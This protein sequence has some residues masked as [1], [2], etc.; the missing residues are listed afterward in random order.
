M[1]KRNVIEEDITPEFNKQAEL[2]TKEANTTK[3]FKPKDNNAD[4]EYTELSL[5]RTR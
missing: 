1:E 4:N 5:R 3:L 2:D